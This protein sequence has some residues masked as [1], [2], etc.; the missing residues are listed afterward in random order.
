MGSRTAHLS[1]AVKGDLTAKM[2]FG[3]SPKLDKRESNG[4]AG[5]KSVLK[6]KGCNIEVLKS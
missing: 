6:Q 2:R 1:R 5:R 3:Q 4:G